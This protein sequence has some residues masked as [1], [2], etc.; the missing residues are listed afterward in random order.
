ME[1]RFET[2]GD[3]SW[4]ELLTRDVE[5]AK[6]FYTE[7]LGWEMDQMPVEGEPYT[8]IK[9]GDREIGGIMRMPAQIPAGTPPHWE[10][11]V[12]VDDVDA[13]ARK[14]EENGGRILV[15]PTDIPHVGR[16]CTLQDPQGAVLCAI[17][18]EKE[19]KD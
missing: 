2:H 18:Y 1:S 14:A 3:F 7:V 12:T 10:S 13:V 11:Y 5:G 4:S 9:T 16:F 15:P 6:R 19:A 8:V 17:T